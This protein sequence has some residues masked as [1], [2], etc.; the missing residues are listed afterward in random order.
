MNKKKV[1]ILTLIWV[2][3]PF[4]GIAQ[5]EGAGEAI[6]PLASNGDSGTS[7]GTG[8]GWSTWEGR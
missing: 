5:Q 2:L 7:L 3:L 6:R 4:A 8:A 1:L